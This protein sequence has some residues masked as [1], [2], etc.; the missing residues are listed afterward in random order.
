MGRIFTIGTR[1]RSTRTLEEQARRA[2][3]NASPDNVKLLE[4]AIEDIDN[5]DYTEARNKIS[6]VKAYID[7]ASTQ[8]ANAINA[9]DGQSYEYAKS[10]VAY[11][12]MDIMNQI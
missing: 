9:I 10:N 7:D 5:T 11:A 12:I 8:L 1:K 6:T 3:N 4:S 2:I